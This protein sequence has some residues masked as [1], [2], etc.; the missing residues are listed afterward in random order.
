MMRFQVGAHVQNLEAGSF[1]DHGVRASETHGS[2]AVT[3][4]KPKNLNKNSLNKSDSL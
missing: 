3:L 1:G 2:S 4:I